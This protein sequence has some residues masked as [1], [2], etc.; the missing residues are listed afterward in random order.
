MR[1]RLALATSF[2]VARWPR[3]ADWAPIVR[4]RL[5]LRLVQHTLDL[6]EP[7]LGVGTVFSRSAAVRKAAGEHG[8]EVH[9]AV[10]GRG[11][12]A[13]GLLLH[14]NLEARTEARLYFH[15]LIAFT[16]RVGGVAAGGRLGNLS[17]PEAADPARR[18]A[19][20]TDL[21]AALTSL[22]IDARRAG[23]ECVLV[24][25]GVSAREASS[26][27]AMRD[28]LRDGDSL[29]AA[30]RACL[31]VGHACVAGGAVAGG[32]GDPYAWLRSLAR[33]APVVTVQQTDGEADR[34]WPFTASRNARG[35][36]DAD[37]V[38]DA[39][40]EGGAEDVILVIDVEAPLTALDDAVLDD[41]A[42]SVDYW[43]EALA[44]RG[45]DEG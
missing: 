28:L 12:A 9:S 35:R 38:L 20:W 6:V 13:S 8:L 2:A 21:Q 36:I 31:D 24:T 43:R 18:G 19:R 10:T 29:H 14:P 3:P 7:P 45:L 41:L 11:A 23:L 27:A 22:A 44:R 30:V 26:E 5:G 32:P 1:A 34:H 16:E 17:S 4:G 42:A 39:L 15:R 25:N 37:A 33:L 40:G